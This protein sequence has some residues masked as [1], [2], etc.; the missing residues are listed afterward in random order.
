MPEF[1]HLRHKPPTP[2]AQPRELVLACAPMRSNVNLSNIVRTAGCCGITR[3]IA[4]G[5]G[6]IDKTIARD[7]AAFCFIDTA[8]TIS[9]QSAALLAL[10]DLVLDTFPFNAGTTANDCLWMGLPILTLSG[11]GFAS[12]VCGSLARAAGLPEAICNSPDEYVERAVAL[13]KNKA[14]LQRLKKHLESK[15]DT[16]VL[17]DMES[18]V[19]HLEALYQQMWKEFHDGRRPRPDLT[20][21]DVYLDVGADADHDAVE[22]LAIKDYREWYRERLTKRHARCAIPEDR[23]FWTAADIAQAEAGDRNKPRGIVHEE[24]SRSFIGCRPKARRCRGPCR[25]W[26]VSRR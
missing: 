25:P 14:E 20:N 18:H 16:C 6:K 8:P 19:R 5:S 7:G 2:L 15:R 10:A 9:D 23:R 1:E 3:L 17:F 26:R 22:V 13:G 21:L 11:H 12:R 24:M 4:C